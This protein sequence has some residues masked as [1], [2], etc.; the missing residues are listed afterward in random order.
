[1]YTSVASKLIVNVVVDTFGN[2]MLKKIKKGR[3]KQ[4]HGGRR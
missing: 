2:W 1:V 4:E 3:L